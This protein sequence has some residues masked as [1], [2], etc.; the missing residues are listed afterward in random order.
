M[1]ASYTAPGEKLTAFEDSQATS[2][3]ISSGV[4]RRPIG[5]SAWERAS[6]AGSVAA[7]LTG[8]TAASIFA[9]PARGDGGKDPAPTRTAETGNAR[10]AAISGFL[11]STQEYYDFFIYGS[12]ARDGA[13]R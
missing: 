9:G 3:A 7:A 6:T 8:F 12:A 5:V 4:P 13:A 2:S 11:G 1:Y 10:R